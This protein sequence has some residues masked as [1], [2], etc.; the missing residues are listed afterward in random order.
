MAF[1][2]FL[3]W[4]QKNHK[5]VR[6]LDYALGIAAIAYG[7]WQDSWI[8]IG[9]GVFCILAALINLNQR[10]NFILPRLVSN[11]RPPDA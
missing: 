2:S 6:L 7:V 10:L 11:K 1:F 9:I 8:S 4:T 3:R 5:W